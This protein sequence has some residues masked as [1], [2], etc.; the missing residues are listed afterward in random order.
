MERILYDGMND[1]EKIE[2]LE[3]RIEYII[4]SN[5]ELQ[6]QIDYYKNKKTCASLLRGL[7]LRGKEGVSNMFNHMSKK[8]RKIRNLTQMVKNR[9]KII[10]Y[11]QECLE[12]ARRINEDHRKINGELRVKIVDLENNIEILF[13]N[14]S[15]QKKKQLLK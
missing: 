15:A 6:T 9:D 12:S 8:D 1:K 10:E 4:K 11:Q 7:I 2:Y 13:N 14:L 5:S 3:K